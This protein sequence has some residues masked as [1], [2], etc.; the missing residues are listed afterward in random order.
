MQTAGSLRPQKTLG[1]FTMLPCK[2][3]RVCF[4]SGPQPQ[5]RDFEN[6][7]RALRHFNDLFSAGH[8]PTMCQIS[9]EGYRV[10]V[11]PEPASQA[12]STPAKGTL[13]YLPV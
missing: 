7:Y 5:A 11:Q 6:S 2:N 4:P 13:H 9:A 3:C 10:C 1:G 8:A 12:A